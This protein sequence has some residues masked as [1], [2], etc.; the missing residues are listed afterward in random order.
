[1][2]RLW[3]FGSSHTQPMHF[4]QQHLDTKLTLANGYCL[5]LFF[6]SFSLFFTFLRIQFLY[7][8]SNQLYQSSTFFFFHPALKG[9]KSYL[10]QRVSSESGLLLFLDFPTTKAVSRFRAFLKALS[11]EVHPLLFNNKVFLQRS[12]THCSSH[13]IIL[14]MTA[15]SLV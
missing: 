10:L 3:H 6:F 11:R 1:M 2:K 8:F 5:G 15:L 14:I 9:F 12:Q 4:C 7:I 13:Q